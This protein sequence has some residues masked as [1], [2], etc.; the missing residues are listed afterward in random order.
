MI[1]Q[2]ERGLADYLATALATPQPT[3]LVRPA[4]SDEELDRT[5][6]MLYVRVSTTFLPGSETHALGNVELVIMTPA[7][8]G[9]N[10][11]ILQGQIEA[12]VLTAMARANLATISTAVEA[13]SGFE[14]TG[15]SWDGFKDGQE[16]QFWSPYLPVI[17]SF[18]KSA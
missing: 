18:V 1:A 2:L 9:A 17:F 8:V 13:A 7:G 3:V 10:T 6:P 4:T 12:A 15:M 5:R 14:A 16:R 11:A